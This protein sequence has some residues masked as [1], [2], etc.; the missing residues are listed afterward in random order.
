VLKIGEFSAL[1]QVS[2]KTLRYYD[3][4]GLLKPIRVDHGSGCRYY[5]ASQL[6]QLHRILVLRDLGFPL[7][8]IA[9]ALDEGVTTDAIRGM[10]ML[11]QAEQDE[12]VREE[13]ERLTRLKALLWLIEQEGVRAG[14]VVLKDVGPQRIASV[15]DVISSYRAIGGLFERLCLA[16]GP[17]ADI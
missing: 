7:N 5:S 12:R 4:L 9:Q 13:S 11:R 6:P 8:R 10:L 2:I 17:V 15:R 1:A 14:E 16:L 3:E